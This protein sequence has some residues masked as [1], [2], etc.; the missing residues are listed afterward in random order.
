MPNLTLME[1]IAHVEGFFVPNSRAQRNNNPGNLNFAPWEA[2]KFGAVLETIPAG[3]NEQP[4]FA[5]F[6]T[7]TAGWSAMQHLLLAD[8]LGRSVQGALS[9]WAPST[10]DNNVPAYVT[11]VCAMC[12]CTPGTLLIAELVGPVPA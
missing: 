3:Y 7:S 2:A 1:A 10:D 9:I 12:G 6:P 11:G 4:R 5:A 8:Y